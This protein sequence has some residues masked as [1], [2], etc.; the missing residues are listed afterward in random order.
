MYQQD[1]LIGRARA[2]GA[3]ATRPA[4]AR[5][6]GQSFTLMCLLTLLLDYGEG[7]CDNV[8]FELY[9]C[10]PSGA[11]LSAYAHCYNKT[12]SRSALYAPD[13]YWVLKEYKTLFVSPVFYRAHAAPLPVPPARCSVIDN[14]QPYDTEPARKTVAPGIDSFRVIKNVDVRSAPKI[15]PPPG[16]LWRINQNHTD[17]EII[18]WV[19]IE[20]P[21]HEFRR[22]SARARPRSSAANGYHIPD[23]LIRR[24]A[25]IKV[26]AAISK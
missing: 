18:S 24:T 14:V 8:S 4:G 22:R 21:F 26:S 11:R 6:C 1:K 20:G 7:P 10:R 5:T 12:P 13:A 19:A 3:R 23:L 25:R 2:R 16:F 15:R 17:N 9:T